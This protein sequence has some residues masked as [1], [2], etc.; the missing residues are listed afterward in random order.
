MPRNGFNSGRVHTASSSRNREM[1]V[2]VHGLAASRY[3]LRPLERQLQRSGYETL[4]WAY[5]SIRGEIAA[6]SETFA[7]R[8]QRLSEDS[9]IRRFHLVTHSMGSIIARAAIANAKFERLGRIVMLGPPHRGSRVAANLSKLLG[10]LCRP[11]AQLSDDPDS[12][13]NN[14]PEPVGYEIGIIA[15]ARDRVVHIESTRLSHQAD[16][17]VVDS[18]HTSMLFREDVSHLVESFLGHGT[19]RSSM[20]ESRCETRLGTV[21]CLN[22]GQI[23]S[24][25]Q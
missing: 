10:W 19:F 14:L 17:I 18:G 3:M 16:H 22:D 11:L 1:V 24:Q 12:F 15:A 9:A 6:L 5:P 8:L 23:C 13:V 4:N 7:R 25:E 21:P 20:L 2:L